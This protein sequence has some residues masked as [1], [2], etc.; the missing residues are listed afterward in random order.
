MS[1]VWKVKRKQTRILL[2][3]PVT[4]EGV[5]ESQTPYRV[6]TVTENVSK[7]GACIIVDRPF[8]LGSIVTV[9]A[10]QGKFK[11]KCEIRAHWVD[12]NDRRKRIGVQFLET[13]VN[14]VVS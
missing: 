5:D 3:I 13:P 14:W 4:I 12:D 7:G 10:S 8:S 9:S 11:C 1:D 2:S 6:D